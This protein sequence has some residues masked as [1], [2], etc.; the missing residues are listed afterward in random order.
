MGGWCQDTQYDDPKTAESLVEPDMGNN[1]FMERNSWFRRRFKFYP[2]PYRS[3]GF[4]FLSTFKHE[5]HGM[6]KP[7]VPG[8]KVFFTLTRATDAF[9]VSKIRNNF[10]WAKPD[11]ENYKVN[12]LGAMLYVKVGQM[13][14]PLYKELKARHQKEPIKYF[15]RGLQIRVTK[16]LIKF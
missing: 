8:S 14:M 6:T 11:S 10:N 1:G 16:L 4:T 15:F 2:A 13:S 5:F 9:A 3:C 7:L 12:I